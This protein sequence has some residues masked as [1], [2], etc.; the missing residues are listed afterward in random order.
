MAWYEQEETVCEALQRLRDGV[1]T[2]GCTSAALLR[3][4]RE[5]GAGFFNDWV[6]VAGS[7]KSVVPWR[8]KCVRRGGW[9]EQ[10]G[11]VEADVLMGGIVELAVAK[12]LQCERRH[13]PEGLVSGPCTHALVLQ[14]NGRMFDRDFLSKLD[15]DAGRQ[16]VQFS[17]GDVLYLGT[18]QTSPGL[19]EYYIS[20]TT[21]HPYPYATFAGIDAASLD[22]AGLFTRMR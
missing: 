5:H 3:I 2:P 15:S 10:A 16:S 22:V 20:R 17:C 12:L 11:R 13:L 1:K 9:W 4:P 18:L 7:D 14:V 19:R 6:S 21:G 8:S